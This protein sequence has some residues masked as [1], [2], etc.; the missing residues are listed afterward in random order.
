MS[1]AMTLLLGG[2]FFGALSWFLT[3]YIPYG[4]FIIALGIVISAVVYAKNESLAMSGL[5]FTV[6]MVFM[7]SMTVIP[8]EFQIYVML[9]IGVP[10][11][12]LILYLVIK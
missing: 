2:D 4:I 9:L 6:Y 7:S 1:E 5:I 10:I 8:L 3:S 11:T 12:A